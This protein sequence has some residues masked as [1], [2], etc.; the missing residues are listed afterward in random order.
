MT[1][2]PDAA[3]AEANA[4]AQQRVMMPRA[5]QRGIDDALARSFSEQLPLLRA[6]TRQAYRHAGELDI[7]GVFDYTREALT[8]D[9]AS[10]LPYLHPRLGQGYVG[11]PNANDMAARLL[12]TGQENVAILPVRELVN[13]KLTQLQQQVLAPVADRSPLDLADDVV[14]QLGQQEAELVA[15]MRNADAYG[16]DE[17]RRSLMKA[18]IDPAYIAAEL[19][20]QSYNQCIDQL[21]SNKAAA[22]E[23]APQAQQQA[24]DPL[25]RGGFER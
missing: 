5:S 16:V 11:I 10:V 14:E 4:L 24:Q 19:S 7:F 1:V 18:Q 23:Q 3:F 25:Q 9:N 2:I 22:Q 17:L 20:G 12:Q 13:G 15:G 8:D 6:A 21:R